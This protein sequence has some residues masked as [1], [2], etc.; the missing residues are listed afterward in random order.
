MVGGKETGVK[1]SECPALGPVGW[2]G[3]ASSCVA[4]ADHAA[5]HMLLKKAGHWDKLG[6]QAALCKGGAAPHLT[7]FHAVSIDY[8]HLVSFFL[9]PGFDFFT[10]KEKYGH[11]QFMDSSD[12]MFEAFHDSTCQVKWNPGLPWQAGRPPWGSAG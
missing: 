11:G 8:F 7:T 3:C 2:G 9:F 5:C 12:N 6:R 1:T 10:E 4:I